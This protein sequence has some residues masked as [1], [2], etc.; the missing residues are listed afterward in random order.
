VL[1]PLHRRGG[2]AA[3]LSLTAGSG[4]SGSPRVLLEMASGGTNPGGGIQKSGTFP[5]RTP[6]KAGGLIPSVYPKKGWRGI[7]GWSLPPWLIFRSRIRDKNRL[8]VELE[9]GVGVG[10]N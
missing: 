5:P 7:G 4:V 2:K 6:V 9:E 10:G 1:G 8:E 3:P